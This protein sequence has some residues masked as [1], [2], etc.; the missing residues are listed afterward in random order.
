M[1]GRFIDDGWA[2]E[3]TGSPEIPWSNVLTNGTFGSIWTDKGGAFAWC[4]NSVLDRLTLWHQDLVLNPARRSIYLCDK[5]GVIRTLTPLP[6]EGGAQWKVIHGIGYSTYISTCDCLETRLDVMVVPGI[7]AEIMHVRVKFLKDQPAQVRLCS[8][9]DIMLGTWSEVH[10]EF[11]RLFIDVQVVEDSIL[12]YTKRLDTR[13]GLKE[14]WNSP[15]PGAVACGCSAPLSG[16]HTDRTEFYGY[17]GSVLSPQALAVA[18][19]K[20]DPGS[21]GDPMAGCDVLLE[22]KNSQAEAAFITAFGRDAAEAAALLKDV[23]SLSRDELFSRV[24]AFWKEQIGEL[25]IKTPKEELN[26]SSL[27]LRYQAIAARIMARCGLYQ[28]SGAYGFRDQLQDS[29]V[30][31][32]IDPRRTLRQLELHLRHQFM[33]GSVLHWWHPETET[34]SHIMCSDDYLWPIMV[35]AEY[36]RETGDSSFLDRKVPFMDGREETIWKHLNRSVE[37]SWAHRSERGIPLLGECDWNDGISSAGDKGKGESFWVA[38]F[39][40]GLLQ[41]M[42]E[43]AEARGED[44]ATYREKAIILKE[45]V[46]TAGWD[47]GWYIQATTDEGLLLGSSRS[48]EGK[49][50]LNPQT[51]SIMSGTASGAYADRAEKVMAQVLRHLK[52]EW[53]TLLLSPAYETPD[54]RIGYITR[55]PPGRRENG[56]V[57]THAAVWAGRAARIMGN[58]KL[59]QEFLLCLLP[60]V[61]G[62]DPRYC[63]EPYVT[64]G[65]MDGPSTPTPG[66]GGWTWYTG[67]AAWLMRSLLE[68]LL[69]VRAQAKGLV[70]EPMV[71]S[72]WKSFSVTRPFRGKL[73][74]IN[75]IQGRESQLTVTGPGPSPGHTI[76]GIFLPVEMLEKYESREIRIDVIYTA[77]VDEETAREAAQSRKNTVH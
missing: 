52:M 40:H 46:N 70:L 74:K 65:N 32:A 5:Q 71:P 60:P 1:K 8:F 77:P 27:W 10:R 19:K 13:P 51:W 24:K 17:G 76:Q 9:Q 58:P 14:G 7:D 62:K 34:G 68:D 67:S 25:E 53:G 54:E 73:L 20:G 47:G 36:Y 39:L 55:Y 44:V 69:G 23:R 41:D 2:Y 29:L 64:P 18:P 45:L 3:I 16:Y 59:V 66:K 72:E 48:P 37:R 30:H 22:L 35:A 26:V 49:L 12:T 28:A 61:R 11:S 56:G 33:D 31:L 42:A 21:W 63:A 75:F 38:H 15:F 4:G 50:H 6:V 57:Y 43:L